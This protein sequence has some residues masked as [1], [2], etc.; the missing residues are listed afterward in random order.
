MC[1]TS[2]NSEV[3][4]LRVCFADLSRLTATRPS[5]W[6]KRYV[7]LRRTANECL[8]RM[9]AYADLAGDEPAVRPLVIQLV[10]LV[11]LHQ[12]EWPVVAIDLDDPAYVSSRVSI[13]ATLDRLGR[14]ASQARRAA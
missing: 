7:G 8:G 2:V 12:A 14:L 9:A 11:S 4:R 1:I 13:E 6:R 10:H 3:V 5:D